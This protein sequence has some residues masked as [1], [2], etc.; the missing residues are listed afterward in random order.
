MACGFEHSAAVLD[1]GE[2][3]CWGSTEFGQCAPGPDSQALFLP[4]PTI[5]RSLRAT[6]VTSVS[7]GLYHTLAVAADGALLSWGQ[8]AQGQLGTGDT[9]DRRVPVQVAGLWGLPVQGCAAG[10]AH[11]VALSAGGQVFAWGR[12]QSGALGLPDTEPAEEA[13]SLQ[14]RSRREAEQRPSGIHR[15]L[16]DALLEMG[17][18]RG[19]AQQAASMTVNIEKALDWALAEGARI[20][21]GGDPAPSPSASAPRLDGGAPGASS[22]ASALDR[23]SGGVKP[24]TRGLVLSPRRCHTLPE[25]A[26]VAAGSN[27]TIAV[28]RDGGAFSFGQGAS[29]ALGA[30]RAPRSH[31]DSHEAVHRRRVTLLNHRLRGERGKL[32][33]LFT[34]TI[35]PRRAPQATGAAQTSTC[36]G[37]SPASRATPSSAAPRGRSTPSSSLRRAA[38]SPAAPGRTGSSAT[39]TRGTSSSR[40]RRGFSPGRRDGLSTAVL[41]SWRRRVGRERCFV[42]G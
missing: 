27:F 40:S 34:L 29:G 15:Q 8:N 12:S 23:S 22:S 30:R 11:S 9:E 25:C 35:H 17:I 14:H 41:F 18:E 32:T 36:P 7:C 38:S 42:V 31:S 2:V 26:A 4:V 13:A 21:S 20:A 37:R 33:P 1:G 10:E 6:P 16:F 5:A 39:R 24:L 3:A 28:V 19:I